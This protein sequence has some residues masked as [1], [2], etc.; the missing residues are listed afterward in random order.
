MWFQFIPFRLLALSL[1]FWAP[2]P[3]QWIL[4]FL[5]SVPSLPCSFLSHLL[6]PV[7]FYNASMSLPPSGFHL[8]HSHISHHCSSVGPNAI[9]SKVDVT[10]PCQLPVCLPSSLLV[11][12]HLTPSHRIIFPCL[13]FHF[14]FSV[15]KPNCCHL[16]TGYPISSAVS[17]SCWTSPSLAWDVTFHSC[18]NTVQL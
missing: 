17:Q 6:C 15:I 4:I 14:F 9:L 1:L 7:V 13:W 3:Y 10:Y 8:L 11:W 2:Y 12:S 18:T 5:Y 16:Y